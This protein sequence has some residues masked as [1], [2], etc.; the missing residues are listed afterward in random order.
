MTT[1]PPPDYTAAIEAEA[2]SHQEILDRDN[3]RSLP[4]RIALAVMGFM[5]AVGACGWIMEMM[6]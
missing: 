5:F 4:T 2:R 3:E 1:D 6:R